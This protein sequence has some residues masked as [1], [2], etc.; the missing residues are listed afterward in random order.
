MKRDYS[1]YQYTRAEKYR[2]RRSSTKEVQL[3]FF[4][5]HAQFFPDERRILI[6]V[7]AYNEDIMRQEE[8]NDFN[9]LEAS[10]REVKPDVLSPEEAREWDEE[11]K[12]KIAENAKRYA[13]LCSRYRINRSRFDEHLAYAYAVQYPNLTEQPLNNV[14]SGT[15]ITLQYG[16][17]ILDFV[18]ADFLPAIQKGIALLRSFESLGEQWR[19]ENPYRAESKPMEEEKIYNQNQLQVLRYLCY[20]MTADM[21]NEIAYRSLYSAICPPVFLEEHKNSACLEWYGSYLLTLQKEYRELLEFCFDEEFYPDVLGALHPAERYALYRNLHQQ[22]SSSRREECF[23]FS[24]LTM[25]G[26][27]K[28]YGTTRET[29]LDRI[30]KEPEV[31]DCHREFAERYGI[32]VKKLMNHIRFPKFVEINYA[33][34]SI[35]QILE[36]EF[37]KMLEQDVRFRKCKR[38][39]RY[40][41]MKGNYDTR[42]CDRI[43]PGETR[44][45]QDLAAQEN[46]KRKVEDDPAL[47]IYS[48]YYKRY[49][50]RVKVRQIKETDFKKWKYRA[51]TKRNECSDGKISPEELIVWM[52]ESFPNRVKKQ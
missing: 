51:M 31:T 12:E 47:P 3:D 16:E 22:P 40:F 36:L 35:A 2:I 37:T 30:T 24:A 20:T 34:G 18:Y 41:I 14:L 26:N 17:G 8:L 52:E 29:F 32:E 48:K 10:L 46:Y 45:C 50:A 1:E 21:T 43:A 9:A 11:R 25:N 7:D 27:E 19:K 4:A 33:F 23:A 49:A 39:G 15:H 6:T 5:N 42:Y 28:P 44:T 13:D 38:C